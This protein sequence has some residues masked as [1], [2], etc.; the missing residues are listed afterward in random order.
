M[1]VLTRSFFLFFC[2]VYFK[3]NNKQTNKP[4]GVRLY[5]DLFE[6]DRTLIWY[7]RS[8]EARKCQPFE[9]EKSVRD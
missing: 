7:I 1:C 8:E 4:I 6:T 9:L 3:K 5:L 2:F